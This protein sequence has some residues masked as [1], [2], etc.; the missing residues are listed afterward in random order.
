M[1]TKYW[2]KF[3][4]FLY[5]LLPSL[6]GRWVGMVQNE[7]EE[8]KKVFLSAWCSVQGFEHVA[9]TRPGP[10]LLPGKGPSPRGATGPQPP[11]CWL[12]ICH[13]S[14]WWEGLGAELALGTGCSFRESDGSNFALIFRDS[15]WV[16]SGWPLQACQV[17]LYYPDL[18]SS[19]FLPSTCCRK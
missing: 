5:T 10:Q 3:V 9:D 12:V 2:C 17:C 15:L 16:F 19:F 13:P 18:S 11:G 1:C 14:W 4:I 6:S 7:G 8:Q